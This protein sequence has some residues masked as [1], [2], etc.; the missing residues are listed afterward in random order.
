MAAISVITA[1]F[2]AEKHLMGLIDSLQTQTDKDFEWVVVDGGST[3][4]TLEIIRSVEGINVV[5]ISEPDFGIYDALNK[6]VKKSSGDFYVAIGADDRFYEDAIANFKDSVSSDG[7]DY[8]IVAAGWVANNKTNYAGEK[9]GAL[10]GMRGV[11]SCHAV[12]TLIAKTLHY[13]FGYYSQLYPISADQFFIKTA[14]NGGATVNRARF[15]AGVYC[16]DGFSSSDMATA[17][18]DFFRVQ[19]RTE[20]NKPL[21]LLLYGLRLL[22]HYKRL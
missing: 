8:D 13:R 20:K 17:L 2:N 7:V 6:G 4:K 16:A 9:S 21:Q 15:I 12:A 22:K 1:T 11:A 19:L 18:S 3:D 10:Y 5:L 14:I